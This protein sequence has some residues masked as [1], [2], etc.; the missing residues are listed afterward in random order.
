[1]TRALTFL[2]VWLLGLS[3]TA[4][5][6]PQPG[7]IELPPVQPTVPILW[8]TIPA[9][10]LDLPAA[11]PGEPVR[12]L[13]LC[14]ANVFTGQTE[15][16]SY[17]SQGQ[18]AANAVYA[19]DH[20]NPTR[21]VLIPIYLPTYNS[22]GNGSTGSELSKIQ[23]NTLPGVDVAA[24]RNQYYADRVTLM[25]NDAGICGQA[26]INAASA[27][28]A[29]AFSVVQKGCGISNSSLW[30]EWGHNDGLCHDTPNASGC[31][32]AF[33][34]GYGYCDSAHSRKS[35]MTYPSPCNGSRTIF[36]NKDNN[37]TYG[38]FFGDATHDEA[39]VQ[40]W[41]MPIEANFRPPPPA[42]PTPTGV[43]WI[44]LPPAHPTPTGVTWTPQSIQH[45]APT[46]V[47]WSPQ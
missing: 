36:S 42:H 43:T 47:T 9:P 8:M 2:G 40:R 10:A 6:P 19:E 16:A 27:G 17:A 1:M 46:A 20:A 14:P 35:P 18:N 23:Q 28:A 4:Q 45:P 13:I 5:P 41:A 3:L 32:P 26:F 21:V 31:T 25:N 7:L 37:W 39:A 30:H 22:P 12:Q 29:W 11:P 15:C 44:A 33:P 34:Y 24:L 38:Y